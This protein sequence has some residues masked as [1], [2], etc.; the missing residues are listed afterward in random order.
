MISS[1]RPAW[2]AFF[3]KKIHG[4]RSIHGSHLEKVKCEMRISLHGLWVIRVHCC[5]TAAASHGRPFCRF[6]GL[7]FEKWEMG[8]VKVHFLK[9]KIWLANRESSR[10]MWIHF[11]EKCA[12]GK[13]TVCCLPKSSPYAPHEGHKLCTWWLMEKVGLHLCCLSSLI[14]HNL[15]LGELFD[16]YPDRPQ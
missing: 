2:S 15:S 14:K 12:H 7:W 5:P 8:I 1:V 10:E 6:T 4:S 16:I 13:Y 3:Q 11:L 9:P